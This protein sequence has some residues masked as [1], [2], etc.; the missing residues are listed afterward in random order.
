[1][2]KCQKNKYAAGGKCGSMSLPDRGQNP[3]INGNFAALLASR[4]KQDLLFSNTHVPITQP[5][6]KIEQRERAIVP[7]KNTQKVDDN[8]L[9]S[10]M[11]YYDLVNEL[12]NL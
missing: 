6:Q 11:Q 4:E 7:V 5:V 1:M 3:E 9:V 12:K 2:S 10:L 8:H